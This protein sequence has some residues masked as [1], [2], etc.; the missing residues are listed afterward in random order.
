MDENRRLVRFKTM[1]N[2][3]KVNQF[4]IDS[5]RMLFYNDKA[6]VEYGSCKGAN[7]N[8]KMWHTWKCGS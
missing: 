7:S 4:Y 3:C 5:L 2:N 1:L 6:Y 8:E